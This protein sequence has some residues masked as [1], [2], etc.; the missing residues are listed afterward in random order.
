[1]DRLS[2]SVNF[3]IAG[4]GGIA[5][6][7]ALGAY[8]GNMNFP[9]EYSLNLK[10]IVTR[11]PMDFTVGR[12]ENF[13]NMDEVLSDRNID[14]IDICTPNN[15]HLEILKKAVEA[16]KSVY[17]EKPLS[18]CMEDSI[19]MEKLV[20]KNK[21][22]NAVALIYRY[23]PAVRLIK[24]A[25]QRQIIGDIIDFKVKLYHKS[26]LNPL[27]KG[28]WRTKQS[29][30][31]GALV[32]LGVHLIDMIHFT[33]GRIREVNC[34]TRVFFKDRTDVDEIAF[35]RM[36]MENGA[37]GTLEVSRIFAQEDEPTTYTLYGTKG[38]IKMS[39]DSP[40]FMEFYD[41]KANRVERI[42]SIQD[43]PVSGYYP[44]ER[45][46]LGFHQDCHTACIVNFADSIFNGR[47]SGNIATFKDSL[48][49]E[50]VI[51]TCYRS[52]REKR[53]IEV[54]YR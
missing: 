46:S 51:D 48:D 33:L 39:S 36:N 12:V 35:C 47:D 23:M 40:Y 37:R 3:A 45:Q 28:S 26:Y 54:D 22:K 11:R 20:R 50:T 43:A 15:S 4:F 2:N 5:R 32:D 14:F 44:G 6:T 27:K 49:S 42:S 1:M 19:E 29:S 17:C 9:L 7:H 38:S 52:D 30:G 21:L 41:Y 53:T 25:I 10:S 8:M 31:G 34:D 13:I 18:S 16:G 24:T